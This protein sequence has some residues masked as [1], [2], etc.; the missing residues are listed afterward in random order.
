MAANNQLDVYKIILKK[1]KGFNFKTLITS[2]YVQDQETN[3]RNSGLFNLLYKAILEQ[4]AKEIWR[5]PESKIGLTLFKKRG[6][7]ENI[8]ISFF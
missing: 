6:E 7:K 1:K 2:R 3:Y 5:H 4:I 8:N